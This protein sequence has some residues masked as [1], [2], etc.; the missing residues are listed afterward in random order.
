[1]IIFAILMIVPALQIISQILYY[2]CAILFGIFSLIWTWK[3]FEK[4]GRPG[5]WA[6]IGIIIELPGWILIITQNTVAM[7]IGALLMIA[8]AIV[9]VVMLGIVAWGNA[10][11]KTAIRKKSR[12]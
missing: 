5:W 4:V 10:P 1:M 8:G 3:A 6:I 7:I 2:A 11:G 12:K 9:S